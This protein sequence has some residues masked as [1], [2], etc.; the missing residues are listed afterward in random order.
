LEDEPLE[1]LEAPCACTG[2]Q[3]HAHHA[4]IQKWVNEKHTL[5]CEICDTD[6]KGSY[7]VPPLPP[8]LS[9]DNLPLVTPLGSLYVT[10]AAEGEG[11]G[12]RGVLLSADPWAD[13]EED[14]TPPAMS[15]CASLLVFL[16]F[17]LVLH[18]SVVLNVPGDTPGAP[19]GVP[20]G[21]GA[22]AT[23]PGGPGTGFIPDA[24]GGG[25]VPSPGFGPGG[26][27]S[28]QGLPSP[29]TALAAGLSLFLLWALTKIMLVAVP[30]ATLMRLA[31]RH[32][33]EDDLEGGGLAAGGAASSAGSAS[34]AAE[35]RQQARLQQ[36]LLMLARL[37]RYMQMAE[38]ANGGGDNR[39][40]SGR[41][42]LPGVV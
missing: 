10:I 39:G 28:G 18:H 12:A 40:T 26:A 9:P 5:R 4:C 37:R 20:T 13:D 11:G 25:L 30:L 24:S 1:G 2:T 34:G 31:A 35:R 36:Q 3:R 6:Y 41:P 7:T 17:M 14:E 29:G 27:P 21:P 16:L 33:E 38:A 22:A 19:G 23:L 42:R 32:Q 8:P 15:W